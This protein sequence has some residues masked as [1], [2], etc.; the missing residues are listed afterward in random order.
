MCRSLKPFD[1]NISVTNGADG[2]Y[3]IYVFHIYPTICVYESPVPSDVC[4]T[5]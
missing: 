1:L 3:Y 5:V 2:N 4:N